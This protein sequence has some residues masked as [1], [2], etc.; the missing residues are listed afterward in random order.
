MSPSS[1][2]ALDA[3]T[4]AILNH[5]ANAKT[6]RNDVPPPRVLAKCTCLHAREYVSR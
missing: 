4:E 3:P 5:V 2:M 6:N 1:S